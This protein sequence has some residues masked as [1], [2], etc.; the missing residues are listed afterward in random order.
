MSP[1]NKN[2]ALIILVTVNGVLICI[3]NIVAIK[4]VRVGEVDFAASALIYAFTFFITDVISEV[5]GKSYAKFAVWSGVISNILMT[6]LIFVTIHLPESP[7]WSL[8]NEFSSI[9]GAVPRTVI[10]SLLAY[11]I[12][13]NL[14]LFIFHKI[15]ERTSGRMLWLR[16]NA[17]TMISQLADSFVFFFVG[18]FWII[19]I[20]TL[21]S[22]A[23]AQYLIKVVIAIIDTALIYP[24]RKFLLNGVGKNEKERSTTD[25]QNP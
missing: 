4:I 23:I 22:L 1:T 19:P 3:S 11:T 24:A 17:S 15:K 7:I 18:F 20:E 8:Q 25:A 2:F 16:N 12:S 13:Q 6:L 21:V 14:D 5:W 10:A 9:L